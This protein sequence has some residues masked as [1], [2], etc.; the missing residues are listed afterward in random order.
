MKTKNKARTLE[1]KKE[2]KNKLPRSYRKEQ[3]EAK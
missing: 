1:N 2:V 3:P